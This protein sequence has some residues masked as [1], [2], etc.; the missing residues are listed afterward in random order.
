MKKLIIYNSDGITIDDIDV[1]HLVNNSL[2]YISYKS[3]CCINN[4]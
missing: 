2:L 4:K 3:K 1:V